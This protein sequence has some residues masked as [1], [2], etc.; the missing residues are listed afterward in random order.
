[1]SSR[2]AHLLSQGLGAT[3]TREGCFF[4]M[5]ERQ[6]EQLNK[7]DPIKRQLYVYNHPGVDR[8]YFRRG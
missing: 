6:V 2:P 5:K 7:P 4:G 1:M 3:A 8:I